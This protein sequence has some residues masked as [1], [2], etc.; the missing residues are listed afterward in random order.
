MFLQEMVALRTE[1]EPRMSLPSVKAQLKCESPEIEAQ[2]KQGKEERPTL[3]GRG[4]WG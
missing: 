1:Q 3:G 4:R 2:K